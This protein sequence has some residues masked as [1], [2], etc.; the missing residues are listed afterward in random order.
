MSE[1]DIEKLNARRMLRVAS[2]STVFC[3]LVHLRFLPD[4][5]ADRSGFWLQILLLRTSWA[6]SMPHMQ[7]LF[8]VWFQVSF[9]TSSSVCCLL[10]RVSV[11]ASADIII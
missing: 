9:C 6:L 8:W 1:L 3:T 5:G 2:W 11:T 4:I 7:S 10:H